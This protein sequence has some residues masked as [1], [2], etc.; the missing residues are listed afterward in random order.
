MAD[1]LSKTNTLSQV[2]DARLVF[3]CESRR[4][5]AESGLIDGHSI[6]LVYGRRLRVTSTMRRT[7]T[8]SSYNEQ[9]NLC[10][11]YY[12]LVT[13]TGGQMHSMGR[14]KDEERIACN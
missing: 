11:M 1:W 13:T 6:R 4:Y 10:L 3:L 9:L 2:F 12:V 8:G 7:L 5:P 14:G